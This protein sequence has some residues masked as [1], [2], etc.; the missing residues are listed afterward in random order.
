MSIEKLLERASKAYY[1]GSPI[2]HDWEFD[3]IADRAKLNNIG[4]KTKD[5]V[6]HMNRLYSLQKIFE[7]E[8]F[9][10]ANA[11]LIE[12]PKLDGACVSLLYKQGYLTQALTRGDGIVGI[13][14]TDKI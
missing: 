12:T 11:D 14:I 2:M 7:G 4:Y 13:D 9:P 6:K 10:I 1:E 5:G 3:A 8:K